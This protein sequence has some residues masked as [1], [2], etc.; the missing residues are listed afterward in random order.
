[1]GAAMV[2]AIKYDTTIHD[3][4]STPPIDAAMAG[5]AVATI[6]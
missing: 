3:A 1:M 4:R 2:E 6:V 5:S